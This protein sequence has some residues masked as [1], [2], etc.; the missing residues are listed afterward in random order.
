ME[1]EFLSWIAYT[2]GGARQGSEATKVSNLSFI[3]VFS[4]QRWTPE[5]GEC[6]FRLFCCSMVFGKV[7][8][9]NVVQYNR[10]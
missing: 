6:D 2:S 5:I 1:S 8:L 9:T 7:G 4:W 3:V 10:C